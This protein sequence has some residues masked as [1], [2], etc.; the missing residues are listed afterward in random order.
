MNYGPQIKADC[1][2]ILEDFWR[3]YDKESALEVLKNIF[4]Q[5]HRTKF[6]VMQKSIPS[7]GALDS[8]ALERM[9]QIFNFDMEDQQELKM[10]NEDYTKLALWVQRTH[11]YL[12][13]GGILAWD[14]ARAVHLVRLSF[15]AGYLDDN[16]A[17]KEILRWAPVIEGKYNDWMA[18]SQSFLIG[19][20]FWCGVDDPETKSIAERLLGHPLSPWQFISWT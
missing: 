9:K 10:S 20:T 18:F 5:G 8:V 12:G 1:I 7:D 19:R 14:V 3:V 11:K 15:I 13:E 16:E 17:W 2:E 6:N 4:E